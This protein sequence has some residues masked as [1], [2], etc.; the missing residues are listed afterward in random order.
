M[1][2]SIRLYGN[3]FTVLKFMVIS[4]ITYLQYFE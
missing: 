3:R 2:N 1:L 4:S